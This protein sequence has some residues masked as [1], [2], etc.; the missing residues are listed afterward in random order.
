D[1]GVA[2]ELAIVAW[3][4]CGRV[5]AR[6]RVLVRAQIRVQVRTIRADILLIGADVGSIALDIAAVGGDVGLVV[7]DVAL[8]VSPGALRRVVMPQI[9]AGRT[10]VLTVPPDVTAGSANI[11][12]GS[13]G[14]RARL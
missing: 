6:Q 1:A 3:A 10:D 12:P 9:S 11:R 14:V 5:S 13:G 8:V 4:A 2:W 7:H